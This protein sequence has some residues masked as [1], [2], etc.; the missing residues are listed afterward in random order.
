MKQSIIILFLSLVFCNSYSQDLNKTH[1]DWKGFVPLHPLK[2]IAPLDDNSIVILS[3]AGKDRYS[4]IK[5]EGVKQKWKKPLNRILDANKTKGVFEG[6]SKFYSDG[7]NVTFLLETYHNKTYEVHFITLSGTNGDIVAFK[8]LFSISRK[9]LKG[10]DIK[11]SLKAS[12]NKDHLIACIYIEDFKYTSEKKGYYK[13]EKPIMA[14]I[15]DSNYQLKEELLL[16]QEFGKNSRL[17]DFYVSNNGELITVGHTKKSVEVF[18]NAGGEGNMASFKSDIKNLFKTGPKVNI[19]HLNGLL[20]IGIRME[21]SIH[22]VQ[23]SDEFTPETKWIFNSEK[24]L[25]KKLY[26]KDR[27]KVGIRGYKRKGSSF[28]GLHLDHIIAHDNDLLFIFEVRG[29]SSVFLSTGVVFMRFNSDG[30]LIWNDYINKY[31]LNGRN[32]GH[33][34]YVLRQVRNKLYILTNE[35]GKGYIRSLDMSNDKALITLPKM[36]HDESQKSLMYPF[37]T[38]TSTGDLYFMATSGGLTNDN[39]LIFF[40]ASRLKNF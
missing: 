34:S 37:A 2:L 11:L 32:D 4:L 25:N 33:S 9:Q 26:P 29:S 12:Q 39:Y 23:F 16:K 7:K 1:F 5:Y 10:A 40:E 35:I 24:G 22:F 15:Y 8:T 13:I 36:I 27:P 38:W 30:K 3:K 18:R 14:F 28:G 6:I 31:Q 20:H 17:N 21:E 19:V